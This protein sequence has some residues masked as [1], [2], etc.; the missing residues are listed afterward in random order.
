[1]DL[2]ILQAILSRAQLRAMFAPIGDDYH[3]AIL[4]TVDLPNLDRFRALRARRRAYLAAL[5]AALVDATDRAAVA[6]IGGGR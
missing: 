2:H 4:L 6:L 1:M 5:N 3:T